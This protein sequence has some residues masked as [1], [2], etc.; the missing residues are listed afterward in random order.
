MGKGQGNDS[1][2]ATVTDDR[3]LTLNDVIWI[4]RRSRSSIFRD[5][6]SGRFPAPLKIGPRSIGWRKS[7]IQEW[8]ASLP[9]REE[10][11]L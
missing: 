5:C 7:E 6:K 11:E 9:Q 4:C 1:R 10:T 8:L 2:N 3:I